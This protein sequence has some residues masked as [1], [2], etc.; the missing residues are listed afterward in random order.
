MKTQVIRKDLDDGKDKGRRRR[1]WQRMRWLDGVTDSMDM[2]LSKLWR[3]WRTGKPRLCSPLGCKEW[4]TAEWLNNNKTNIMSATFRAKP[5]KTL[6]PKFH[7]T[8]VTSLIESNEAW[9]LSSRHKSRRKDSHQM[10]LTKIIIQEWGEKGR[11]EFLSV[12][13]KQVPHYCKGFLNIN[14][15][16]SYLHSVYEQQS[17][18]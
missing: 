16:F 10:S 15:F 4:D 2:S 7:L 1:G 8:T 3:W 18:W 6:T 13:K 12:F 11:W 14:N 17:T 5:V 9:S